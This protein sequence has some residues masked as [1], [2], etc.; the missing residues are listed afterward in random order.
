MSFPPPT[1]HLLL[2]NAKV[3]IIKAHLVS[4]QNI[5]FL[6]YIFSCLNPS[7]IIVLPRQNQISHSL[8]LFSQPRISYC[9]FLVIRELMKSAIRHWTECWV[10]CS[11]YAMYTCLGNYFRVKVYS[12]HCPQSLGR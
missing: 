8:N 2:R 3:Q 5:H 12:G 4:Y 10:L 11:F 9:L 6:Q 1:H 7:L